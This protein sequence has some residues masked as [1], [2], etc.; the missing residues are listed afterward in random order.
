MGDNFAINTRPIT[1]TADAGQQK[2]YGNADPAFTFT[3]T[4]LGSGIAVAGALTRVAGETVLGGPY[5]ITQG[6][7]TNA[8]NTN[9][10]ITY[11]GDNFA[12][13]TRPITVTADA[14]QQKTYGNADPAIS[15]LQRRRAWAAGSRWPGR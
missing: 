3:T 8:N 7:V 4:S 9:Y 1:V 12:I 6:T 2:T 10:A 5:A 11:V 14:G 15:R 13:N